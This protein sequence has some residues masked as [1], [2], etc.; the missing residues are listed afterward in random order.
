[1]EITLIVLLTF[2]CIAVFFYAFRQKS[3]VSFFVKVQE[4]NE[5]LKIELEELKDANAELKI[6]NDDLT[7]K[8][9]EEEMAIS[10][11][12]GNKRE[13]EQLL[14]S[15]IKENDAI[16][17]EVSEKEEDA[18]RRIKEAELMHDSF[19]VETIHEMRTPLSLILGSLSLIVQKR[20]S[21]EDLS[22]HLLSAYR[23]TLALQDLA[24]QLI[25]T[26][27]NN[28]IADYLRIARYD[29]IEISRQ[30]CDLFVDWV[31]MNNIDFCVNTEVDV[32]WVWLD[33]RKIEYALRTLLTNA[34]KNTFCFGKVALNISVVRK[35]NKAYCCLSVQDEGLNEQE[36]VRRGL[37]QIVDM[38]NNIGG[39]YEHENNDNGTVYTLYIPLGKQHLMDLRVEFVE[40]ECDLVKLNDRQKE[41]IANLIQIVP[42]KKVTGK[43]LLVIDDSDQIR[44]FLKRIFND[45]YQMLEARNG[46]EGIKIAF[47]QLPDIIL[48]D[49]MMIGKDGFET[50]REI[51]QDHRTA[52]IPVIMLTA[53]VE[54][55]DVLTGIEAGADDYI[56]KPFDIEI[57]RS[58]VNSLLKRREKLWKYFANAPAIDSAEANDVQQPADNNIQANPFMDLVIKNI[59]KHLDDPTFASKVLADS[60]NMSLPTLYRKMKQYSDSSILELTRTIR[61]KKAAELILTQQYTVQEVAEMV[62]FN[63]VATFRKRFTE[64]YGVTPSQYGVPTA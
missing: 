2:F 10:T 45:E 5:K 48:C 23:N 31:S 27:R 46:E 1:M 6:T 12:A 62:G 57:L 24:D 29:M 39:I 40:P 11:L 7:R 51:K 16:I 21:E 17:R 54:N 13:L 44:W 30:I 61:L 35:D 63:D 33:R 55:K 50:C 36:G 19:F 53:K 32:L 9:E 47:E 42:R 52:H 14:V 25:G 26:G 4:E 18:Q 38:I 60:L 15:K 58:K 28:D 43:K 34:F 22:T 8:V 56:T 49:V 3:I 37:K 41:D 59:E 64:Q 20:N